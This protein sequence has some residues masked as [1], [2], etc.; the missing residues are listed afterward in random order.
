MCSGVRLFPI[1]TTSRRTS[2][3]SKRRHWKNMGRSVHRS[4][5]K[6]RRADAKPSAPIFA[7]RIPASPA[8]AAPPPENRSDYFISDYQLKREPSRKNIS[9]RLPRGK[10]AAGRPNCPAAGA[11]LP[12]E[13]AS[14]LV[15]FESQRNTPKATAEGTFDLSQ[16]VLALS[17][18]VRP[19]GRKP[20]SHFRYLRSECILLFR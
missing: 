5:R 11:G 17:R 14:R 3:A 1:A 6:W 19:R 15:L 9:Y 8:R 16:N 13:T 4:P 7:W 12:Q 2:P 20:K 10:Q 18:N